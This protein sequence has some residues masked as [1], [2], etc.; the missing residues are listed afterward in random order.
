MIRIDTIHIK[1]FRGIR[2]LTLELKGQNFAAC[3]PN[4]TG[5][6]GIVDAIEFALTGNISRLAGAG[7]GGLSVRAHGPHVDSRNKPEAAS[8]TIDVTIPSLGSKKARIRRTVKSTNAPEIKPADK[9]VIAAFESV[10]LHPEFVLSRRELIRYVLSEPG[11][12]SKE[13]QSLLRLDDIEKLRGVLQKIAN[14]CTRDLPGL[15]RAEKDAINNLL[16]ALD[17][18]QLSKKS[19]LDAVNPRRTLLGLT[20]LTDLDANTSV[21][22]GLTTTTASVPGRVPK[23]QAAADF[24]T[25]REAL[26]ALKADSFKQ[27]CSTADTNAA[28]LGKDAESLNGL[29]RESLL[30][31]ALELYDGAACPVCD[32]P[33]ESDAFT[34]HL[35]RKLA[36]FEDVS[37][38]RAALEAELKP[39]LDALHAAGTALNTVIDHAGM[40]SPKIDASALAEFRTVLRGRYQQLQKL[41]PL[42]DTRAVLSAA[43]SV[44]DMEPPLAALAAAIAAIPE[45]TKQDAA[46]DFLVL[47]QERLETCRAARLKFTA[48]KVRADRATKVFATYGIVT[49]T[50]LEKIYKD[51]E[52]AFAS[53]Y[54]KINEE[55]EKAFTAKLMPSIG[56]LGFDVDFYGRG[57]FP[58]GAY[59]SEGHQDGMGL[60][61]YLALM[62][63]LLGANFTFAVL[64]DVLMSV[65]AGHR[66]Q[67]CALLKEMFPNTQFIFTTHDE[68]WLRHMKSEG[69]I[70]GRN[71]A[72]FRTWTVDFGPTEWDDRDVWAELEGYLIKNDVRAAAA[73][74]RHYLE[75]FAKEACDRL[76]ANVEF[77]GDAQ[78][79]LGDLLPNATST[80]GD[81][82]KKAKVAANSWNQKDVVERIGAIEVAFAEAKAKTGYENWQIN[83]AVHFNEWADLKKEDFTPV[84]SAF[85]TFTG[86]FGC[87]TCNEMYFV[88]PDR[89]KKEALRCG[90]GDLNLNLLQKKA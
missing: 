68:I 38:R 78:F 87:G 75:H 51:V 13:V 65:D 10:N 59:H 63:H 4:G 1:E 80:L 53:Y 86:A 20:L 61:L 72:H 54:R 85:R 29:S 21:K 2:E 8:V 12:R 31:S 17:A 57:H 44:P 46:R 34:G 52:T 73:L 23:V 40:F 7:T 42:D 18:A 19:V 15:E 16:A 36:H 49:T 24:A 67:V 43:H 33:F 3:G 32:T 90:C 22:D 28:E 89:G 62:N 50:A 35:A 5:K 69:L 14:A 66:R 60:C 56:K 81:L 76:R 55:D 11:Q 26:H 84:V 39:V 6:S 25:L 71:F 47:A 70:K 77:R 79:M 64:D 37:K 74:L 45:P 88:A 82:L 83:T 58:P 27:A 9:D 48:G 30:K 41:L